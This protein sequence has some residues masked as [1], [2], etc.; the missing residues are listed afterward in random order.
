MY[1]KI[2]VPLDSSE[3][4]ECGLEYVKRTASPGGVT[5]VILLRVVEPIF[6]YDAS[7]WAQ[8]GYTVTEVQ[9]KN[10]VRA[11]EYLSQIAARLTSEGITT[12]IEVVEG[13]AAEAI[14]DYAEK[15]NVDLI[16]MS[17]HGRSG[18]SRWAFGSVADRVL[19][20]SVV[21]VLSVV[22]A[23]CRISQNVKTDDLTRVGS[24]S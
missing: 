24:K 12:R 3:L 19:R 18:I 13:R 5:E 23:D 11:K 21:P 4:A 20:H 7:A 15:N 9:N 6:S 1:S 10:K 2:L 14:M 22:P 8:A 17:T 16:I